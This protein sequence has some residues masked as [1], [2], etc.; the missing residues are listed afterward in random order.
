[1]SHFEFAH[2]VGKSRFLPYYSPPGVR[3]GALIISLGHSQTLSRVKGGDTKSLPLPPSVCESWCHQSRHLASADHVVVVVNADGLLR[4]LIR[5]YCRVNNAASS[6][7]GITSSILIILIIAALNIGESS[8]P[9]PSS[10]LLC[11]DDDYD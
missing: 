4:S 11:D 2:G 3:T 8:S 7:H 5:R 10:C 1:M 6:R 9:S